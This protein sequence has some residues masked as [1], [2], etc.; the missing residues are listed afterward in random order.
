M[1]AK[2]NVV[3]R[4]MHEV[5]RGLQHKVQTQPWL[6][7]PVVWLQPMADLPLVPRRF[8]SDLL[9]ASS[10]NRTWLRPTSPINST[11]IKSFGRQKVARAT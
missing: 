1:H 9:Q 4:K 2:Q 6:L 7:S 10:G 5:S 11:G 8:L 3:E